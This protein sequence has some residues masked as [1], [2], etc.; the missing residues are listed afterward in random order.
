MDNGQHKTYG[1]AAGGEQHQGAGEG[2]DLGSA[3]AGS[4][5]EEGAACPRDAPLQMVW[6]RA[7]TL[8][9]ALLLAQESQAYGVHRSGL[10][11][12]RENRHYPAT[13]RSAV[14]LL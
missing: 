7:E 10:L 12:A 2:H 6:R 13:S 9:C 4:F 3:G 1:A 11:L 14:P 8:R 5:R